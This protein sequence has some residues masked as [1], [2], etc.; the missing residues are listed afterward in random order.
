MIWRR[1][2]LAEID[3]TNTWLSVRAAE[4]AAEGL[5]VFA[6]HQRAGRGRLERTW[7]STVGGSLLCSILLRPNVG[8]D[9]LQLVVASVALSARAALVRLS[10]LRPALKWPNDLIIGDEKIGGLLAE[11]VRGATGQGI[12]VGLGVNLTYAGPDDVAATSVLEQTG[13]TITAEALLD[14]LLDELEPRRAMLDDVKG[15]AS[16]RNEYERA[17]ATIGRH[18]RLERQHDTVV[19]LATSIDRAGRLVLDLDGV[20][21]AFAVGDVVHARTTD[22]A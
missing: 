20:S 16:L 9:D 8:P 11:L 19:G 13:V 21:T 15:R 18:V 22:E 10:G 2:H 3:S 5:V 7:E 1:E 17:L 4:G 12:V 14:I 6:D